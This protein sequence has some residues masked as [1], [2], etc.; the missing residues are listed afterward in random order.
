MNDPWLQSG[1]PP[2]EEQPPSSPLSERRGSPR[3][4]PTWKCCTPPLFLASLGLF[5]C[6]SSTLPGD[7]ATRQAACPKTLDAIAA[8]GFGLGDEFETKLK[9]SL[10]GAVYLRQTAAKLEA[11]VAMACANIAADLDADIRTLPPYDGTGKAS[12][13]ACTLAAKELTRLQSE[14]P[15]KLFV[16]SRAPVCESSLGNFTQC[17]TECDPA[18]TPETVEAVCSS[19]KLN[20]QCDGECRGECTVRGNVA[21]Q[22]YCAGTCEGTCTSNFS[23]RCEG[24]CKGTCDGK[25]AYGPCEGVCIGECMAHATGR[26]GGTCEGQCLGACSTSKTG[27]CDGPCRG[28]CSGTMKDANCAGTIE[29]AKLIGE[30]KAKCDAKATTDLDCKTPPVTIHLESDAEPAKSDALRSTL[31]ANLATL[32]SAGN[33]LVASS[34]EEAAKAVESALTALK[35]AIRER[36]DHLLADACLSAALQTEADAM[37]SIRTSVKAATSVSGRISPMPSAHGSE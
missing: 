1:A 14:L 31:T 35:A 22:G 33:D 15:V 12:E 13:R 20:G 27:T 30:C 16:E 26:C 28:E 9:A 4:Q 25:S 10:S 5:A 32:L 21:C 17:A 23:G 2:A 34:A 11:S 7:L 36:K 3:W 6:N 37:A 18:L 29:S 8:F 19:G 24:T